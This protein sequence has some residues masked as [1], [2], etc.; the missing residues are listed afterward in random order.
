[1]EPTDLLSDDPN[2][3]SEQEVRDYL[4]MTIYKLL[5]EGQNHHGIGAVHPDSM[6]SST[7]PLD[8]FS[9]RR[10]PA[11]SRRP[12]AG[13]RFV[14]G[15]P[16]GRRHPDP[17]TNEFH[18]TV[19]LRLPEDKRSGRLFRGKQYSG[20]SSY[21]KWGRDLELVNDI[22]IRWTKHSWHNMYLDSQ[23]FKAWSSTWAI[24]CTAPPVQSASL[25]E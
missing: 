1:M 23:P 17:I 22:R 25:V 19:D 15:T 16:T 14:C 8:V 3:T 9:C 6:L 13:L 10:W 7:A 21:Q 5:A 11:L 18:V 24:T 4:L 12:W 2:W 20:S